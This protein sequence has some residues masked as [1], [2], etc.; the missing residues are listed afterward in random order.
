[1]NN[2]WTPIAEGDLQRLNDDHDYYQAVV[3][4]M[5]RVL[6]PYLTLETLERALNGLPESEHESEEAAHLIHSIYEA[7]LIRYADYDS[8]WKYAF[9]RFPWALHL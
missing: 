3:N 7:D 2:P 6:G 1:M 9:D 4:G 8:T 5:I